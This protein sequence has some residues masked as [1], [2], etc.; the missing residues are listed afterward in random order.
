MLNVGGYCPQGCRLSVQIDILRLLG[1]D[2][3]RCLILASGGGVFLRV[4]LAAEAGGVAAGG[5]PCA[6]GAAGGRFS[7]PARACEKVQCGHW[8]AG[9]AV[10][11]RVG[12]R[13]IPGAGSGGAGSRRVASNGCDGGHPACGLRRGADELCRYC[14][15]GVLG[16][17]RWLG[18]CTSGAG[19]RRPGGLRV[20][21]VILYPDVHLYADGGDRFGTDGVHD[22]IAVMQSIWHAGCAR[23]GFR[24]AP[25]SDRGPGGASRAWRYPWPEPGAIYFGRKPS[26]GVRDCVGAR[27]V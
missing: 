2:V 13:S 17:H 7:K 26:R 10:G 11:R 22:D 4:S 8:T 1:W 3:Y 21:R 25:R 16:R 18:R 5:G 9:G 12:A 23:G 24:G 14:T 6:V 19:R 15:G 27:T 20:Q